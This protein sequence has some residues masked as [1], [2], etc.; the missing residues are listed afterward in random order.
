MKLAHTAALAVIGWYLIVPPLT[1]RTLDGSNV[2]RFPPKG[3]TE[4][5]QRS[6]S[7][8][9]GQCVELLDAVE[10]AD[11]SDRAKVVSPTFS[12]DE[13]RSRPLAQAFAPGH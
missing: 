8:C 9:A 3:R 1:G 11:I 13:E 12:L 6:P 7:D 5:R 10:A 2:L 4:Q